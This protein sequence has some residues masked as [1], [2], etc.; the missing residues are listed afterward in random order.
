MN[1]KLFLALALLCVTFSG[2]HFLWFGGTLKLAGTLEF[3][4]YS[5]GTPVPGRLAKV[6]VK[7]GDLV[8][9]G[10]ELATL[11]RYEQMKHDY[12]RTRE[13]FKSG[14]TNQQALEEAELAMND[15]RVLSPVDGVVLVKVHEAGEVMSAGSPVVQ[16]A[17]R[18]DVWVKVFVPE[19]TINRVVM[20]SPA[21]LR[22]DGINRQFK[23]HVSFIG[24][25]AE[26]TPRNVQT[27]EERVT[28]TFAVKVALDEIED[29]LR[30]GVASDVT[31]TLKD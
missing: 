12:D 7:E 13:L 6:S 26:F 29:F 18:K 20:N 11:E 10:D 28:Q 16:I 3:T 31:L 1:K 14:G 21:T 24:P 5:L 9:T 23:G 22:F 25:K 2:C 19:G 27:A 30:P 8:K 17:A 4:E 15:Q